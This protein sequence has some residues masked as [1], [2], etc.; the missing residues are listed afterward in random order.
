MHYH[1]YIVICCF[2]FHRKCFCKLFLMSYTNYLIIGNKL[3]MIIFSI[4]MAFFFSIQ[5]CMIFWDFSKG[6]LNK[7]NWVYKVIYSVQS[8][9]N[10]KI[11]IK[12]CCTPLLKG[13]IIHMHRTGRK[14]FGYHSLNVFWLNE[15]LLDKKN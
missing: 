6:Y 13:L 5:K 9:N 8:E 12:I 1:S 7:I 15:C 10:G 3:Y 14:R 4:Y 11:F 2:F